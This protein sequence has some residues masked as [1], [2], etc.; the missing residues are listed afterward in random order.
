MSDHN[1]PGHR[2]QR[3]PEDGKRSRLVPETLQNSYALTRLSAREDFIEFCLRESFKTYQ[4]LILF[5]HLLLAH[6]SGSFFQI[7][8]QKLFRNS[9][10]SLSLSSSPNKTCRQRTTHEASH[11]SVFS[12]YFLAQ[13]QIFSSAHHFQRHFGLLSEVRDPVSQPCTL[14]QTNTRTILIF[15]PLCAIMHCCQ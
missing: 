13:V 11:C 14:H 5:Y 2:H 15:P 3:H 1:T 10:L 4:S 6:S 8:G 9:P 7:F 12:S